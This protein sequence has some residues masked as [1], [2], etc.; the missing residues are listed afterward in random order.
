M[1][2]QTQKIFISRSLLGTQVW[3]DGVAVIQ[4]YRQKKLRFQNLGIVFNYENSVV[5]LSLELE[6]SSHL[7]NPKPR[8]SGGLNHDDHGPTWPTA[9]KVC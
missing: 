2:S 7:H 5:F 3:R 6:I 4:I 8:D 1:K 9:A